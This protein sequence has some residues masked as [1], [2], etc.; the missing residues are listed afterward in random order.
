MKEKEINKVFKQVFKTFVEEMF[1]EG[2][3][4]NGCGDFVN[5]IHNCS[6]Y[7]E[8]KEMLENNVEF[9][10][11][12]LYMDMSCDDCSDKDDEI[13]DL[14]DAVSDLHTEQGEMESE[15]S[16]AFVPKTLDD[17]YK[18]EAFIKAKDNFS[19]SEIESLLG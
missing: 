14:E 17:E 15:L 6:T 16:R 18:I 3:L 8:L 2:A 12:K 7:G 10:S 9:I 19:V 11:K 1:E 4:P 13:E 5:E